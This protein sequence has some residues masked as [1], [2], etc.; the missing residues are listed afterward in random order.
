M[1]YNIISYI[2]HGPFSP[3]ACNGRVLDPLNPLSSV[4]RDQT[5]S[6]R[7]FSREAKPPFWHLFCPKSLWMLSD[8][9]FDPSI[10]QK[11]PRWIQNGAKI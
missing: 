2:R 5:P 4:L 11:I 3:S 7:V 10:G 6:T 1:D 8:G 9:S